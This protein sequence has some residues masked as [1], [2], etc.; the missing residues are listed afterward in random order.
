[1]PGKMTVGKISVAHSADDDDAF[2]TLQ[3]IQEQKSRKGKAS[4]VPKVIV[5]K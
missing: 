1:M 2:I 5:F 3:K 4:S